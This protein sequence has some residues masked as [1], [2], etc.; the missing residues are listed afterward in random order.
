MGPTA[1]QINQDLFE[2]YYFYA[3]TLF[4]HGKMEEAARFYEKASRVRPED[5]QAPNLLSM[6]YE[7][8]GRKTEA[9]AAL[10]Q[11]MRLIEKH[12]EM[13]PDDGRALYFG[14]Q[15]LCQLGQPER[16]LDWATRALH[17]DPEDPAVLYNVGC[18][19][20]LMGKIDE[21]LDCLE[22]AV[23]FGMGQKEWFEND[24]DLNAVRNHPRFAAMLK[25]L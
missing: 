22:K 10:M 21:A 16:S 14:A 8:L 24:S 18:V 3:R 11:G 19:Y 6:V 17:M 2:A 5:Y 9:K 4:A 12:L 13:H 15:A 7:V 25:G 20:S 1:I 23:S